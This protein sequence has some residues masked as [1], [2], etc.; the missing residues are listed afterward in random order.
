[1]N[2]SRVEGGLRS[3]SMEVESS[4]CPSSLLSVIQGLYASPSQPGPRPVS[5]PRA[6]FGDVSRQQSST[7]QPGLAVRAVVRPRCQGWESTNRAL[8]AVPNK[9]AACPLRATARPHD[10]TCE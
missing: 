1:M 6:G 5:A 10:A 7:A 2:S 3:A 8:S 9:A 4:A